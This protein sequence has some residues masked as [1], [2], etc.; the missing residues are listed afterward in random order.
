MFLRPRLH[1]PLDALFRVNPPI[2][3]HIGHVPQTQEVQMDE[4]PLGFSLVG[5]RLIQLEGT[6]VKLGC[7]HHLAVGALEEVEHEFQQGSKRVVLL[8][9]GH[10]VF[11]NRK[12]LPIG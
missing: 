10:V 11:L 3:G 4:K 2:L 8:N 1:R 12:R 6:D 9:A 5:L 7:I